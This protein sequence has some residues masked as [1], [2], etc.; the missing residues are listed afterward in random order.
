MTIPIINKKSILWK[1]EYHI[2]VE[3]IDTEHKQLFDMA[4]KALEINSSIDQNLRN[5]ELKTIIS[6]LLMYTKVH[7]AHEQKYMKEIKYPELSAHITLHQNMVEKLTLLI[8]ELNNL[9]LRE[10]ENTLYTFIEEYFLHHI[11]TEDKRIHLWNTPLENLRKD[12][13]WKDFY[14]VAHQHID[15]DHKILFDIAAEAFKTVNSPDRVN[16]IR[17]I[18]KRLYDYMKTHFKN[19]ERYM[20][21]I[22][23]ADFEIHKK[24]HENIIAQ[25]NDFI[26]QLSK[27]K[28]ETFEKELARIIDISLLQHIIQEDRKII[29]WQKSLAIPK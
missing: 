6:K 12:F 26:R 10:I 18:I 21:E 25:L 22:N 11:I 5:N 14:S 20:Q 1:V 8:K 13:G 2:H 16:K 28:L 19:E 17:T 7:F 15:D 29:I 24:L 4:Q 27:I 9:E 3:H 23:Y